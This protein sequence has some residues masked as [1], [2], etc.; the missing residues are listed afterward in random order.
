[1]FDMCSYWSFEINIDAE[2]VD[3]IYPN[4]YN[5]PAHIETKWNDSQSGMRFV[6]IYN[7]W[8][9]IIKIFLWHSRTTTLLA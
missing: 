5:A 8:N 4:W 9:E 7:I 6:R 2:N 3:E 1:M